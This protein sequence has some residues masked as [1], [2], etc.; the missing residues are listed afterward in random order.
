MHIALNVDIR[1]EERLTM[2]KVS[3][4]EIRKRAAK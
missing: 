3:F 4:Q 2:S 1:H